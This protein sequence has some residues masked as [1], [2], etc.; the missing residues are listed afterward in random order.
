M[1]RNYTRVLLLALLF[2]STQL[3]SQQTSVQQWRS[4]MQACQLSFDKLYVAC[5]HFP[6][7]DK[8]KDDAAFTAALQKWQKEYATEEQAFW[9]IEEI[10][11]GNPSP[12]Y[13]GL[14]DGSKPKVFESSIWE[15]VTNSKITDARLNEVA[16]HFPKPKLTGNEAEDSKLYESELDFWMKLYP[17]EYEKLFNAPELI[18]LNPY[19]TGYYKPVLIPAFISAP[20]HETKPFREAYSQSIKGELSYQL[21]LRAWYFVFEPETFNRLYGNQYSFPEW[22]NAEKFRN[23]VKLKFEQ[24]KNPPANA[25]QIH[26]GK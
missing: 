9:K 11:K 20:L 16:A 2:C 8:F 17:L 15:W 7:I 25:E 18:A 21:S 5:P 22:F 6:N 3:F 4:L 10:K 13:L 26:P 24:T 12:Y 19:Y 14:S 1:V 23:D